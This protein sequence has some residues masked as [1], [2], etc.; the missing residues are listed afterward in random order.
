VERF[1]AVVVGAGPAGSVTAY[2]LAR[3]GASVLLLDRAKLP[4]DKPCG[5]GLTGRALKQLPFDVDEVVE[6]VVDRFEF[7]LGYS[8]RAVR[9]AHDALAVMTQR[10]RLDAYLAERAVEAGAEFR[11]EG[12]VTDVATNGA[13]VVT[14]DGKRIRSDVVV[15]ADGVNGITSR[16]LGLAGRYVHGVALEGNV[17]YDVVPPARYRGRA[18]L[19]LGIVPGGYGWVFAKGDHVNVGV[20]GWESEGPR[21]RHLLEELCTRHEIER[22]A[23][24]G[25]RGHRLPL[26]RATDRLYYRRCLVVGDAAGLVDPVSGDGMYEAFVS[27]RLA[28]EAMVDLLAGRSPTLASYAVNVD[29]ALT[30]DAA[31]SWAAKLAF[32]RHPR[33]AFGVLLGPFVW[34]FVD[35]LI[36]GDIAHV[37]D[38]RGPVRFPLRLLERMGSEAVEA[39]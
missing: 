35:R 20:G 1:D 13:A 19:E 12:R 2:H 33:T 29:R 23:V 7:R 36:R 25:V 8:H 17:S 34:S 26:R 32:D 14:V 4:R 16:V 21:L 5:G 30:R 11:D 31:A 39:R 18:V 38:A 6:D 27:A 28:A 24:R 10:R 22:T 3:A 15:G 37:R 9:D